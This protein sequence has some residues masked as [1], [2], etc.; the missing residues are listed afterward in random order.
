VTDGRRA[1][2]VNRGRI[3][4][5]HKAKKKAV[6]TALSERIARCKRLEIL[7]S[8]GTIDYDPKC[9]YKAERKRKR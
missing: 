3:V 8:F 1:M 5:H 7:S 4:G 9:D 6:A 2:L